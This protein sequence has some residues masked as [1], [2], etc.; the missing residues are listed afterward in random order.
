[1]AYT[2]REEFLTDMLAIALEGGINYWAGIVSKHTEDVDGRPQYTHAVIVDT[3]DR[4]TWKLD[5]K[6]IEKGIETALALAA[7]GRI[8][9]V[10]ELELA[11]ATDGRRGDVDAGHAD[12]VVQA[13]LFDA[14]LYG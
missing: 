5:T 7:A 11:D 2:P 13:G 6:V 1:M 14:V 4:S 3:E 10:P 12:L 8:I 9:P